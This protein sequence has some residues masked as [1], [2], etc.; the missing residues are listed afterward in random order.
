MSSSGFFSTRRAETE[1]KATMQMNPSNKVE[2]YDWN[3]LGKKGDEAWLPIED[4]KID[5]SYQR[6]EVSHKNTLDMARDFNW[7]AFGS[8]VVGARNDGSMWVADGQQRVLAARHRQDVFSVPARIFKSSGPKHEAEVFIALNSKRRKVSSVDKFRAL[9]M[10]GVKPYTD[11]DEWLTSVG[12]SVGRYAEQVS[13]PDNLV[14]NWASNVEACKKAIETQIFTNVE[15]QLHRDVHV[16]LF[17]LAAEGIDIEKERT[18]LRERGGRAEMLRQIRSL[19]A[20]AGAAI[21]ER[22]AGMAILKIINHKRKNRIDAQNQR[23][24]VV[25]ARKLEPGKPHGGAR[26]GAGRPRKFS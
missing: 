3:R 11:I 8:I 13:F 22:L 20:E 9:V 6:S 16:G 2:R 21:S 19:A 14:R 12:L 17:W 24:A 23:E 15:E 1:R 7:D 4:L 18:K 10:A 5:R 26:P 25:A